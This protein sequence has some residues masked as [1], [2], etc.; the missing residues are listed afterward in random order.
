V[1]AFVAALA[2][3]SLHL[4]LYFVLRRSLRSERTIFGFHLVSFV[5]FAVIASTLLLRGDAPLVV[6][7]GVLALHGIY[8]LSFLEL[9]SLAQGGYSVSILH[10]LSAGGATRDELTQRFTRLGDAKKRERLAALQDG[11]LI[12]RS[13]PFAP[14]RPGRALAMAIGTFRGLANYRSAG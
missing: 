6:V 3:C 4:T 5:A 8:S 12:T 7:A 1:G 10:A 14:T 2:W 13:A 9:W 11:G